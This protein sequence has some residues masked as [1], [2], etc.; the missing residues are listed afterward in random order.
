MSETAL[1]VFT[2]KSIELAPLARVDV[3]EQIEQMLAGSGITAHQLLL[4]LG[5][6]LT[7]NPNIVPHATPES[8]FNVFYLAARLHTSF[9]DGGLWI[10]PGVEQEKE[11]EGQVPVAKRKGVRGQESKKHIVKCAREGRNLPHGWA[12]SSYLVWKDNE[13]I[14]IERNETGEIAVLLLQPG[15]PFGAKELSDLVGAVA[16]A[17]P[18]GEVQEPT[19]KIMLIS[20]Q[21]LDQLKNHSAA[22][23]RNK[24]PA[25]RDDWME[26]YRGSAEAAMARR[27]C[28]IRFKSPSMVGGMVHQVELDQPENEPRPVIS[29]T[30][31][32]IEELESRPVTPA[33][34]NITESD[35]Q[36]DPPP[37]FQEPAA[38]V[39][40]QGLRGDVDQATGLRQAVATA[41]ASRG[42]LMDL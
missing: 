15:N 30:R 10:I 17:E 18:I 27:L 39:G 2:E 16:V 29:G 20:R 40:L 24:A 42:G 23:K 31:G 3:L 8:L 36:N 26:M 28:P 6:Y 38:S 32:M 4:D 37:N 41:R 1:R 35:S 19:R 14:V 5:A 22:A 11:E 12:I 34:L 7:A 9:G 21:R 13:P 25:W 33:P